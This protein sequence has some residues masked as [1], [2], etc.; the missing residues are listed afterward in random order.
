[1]ICIYGEL[2][3]PEYEYDILHGG[4]VEGAVATPTCHMPCNMI[5][6]MV[7]SSLLHIVGTR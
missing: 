2:D 7:S 3:T 1:M 5:C 4:A 6:M